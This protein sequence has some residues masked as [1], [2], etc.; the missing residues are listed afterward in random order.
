MNN[1]EFISSTMASEHLA[2]G[3]VVVQSARLRQGANLY[4]ILVEPGR[5][6]AVWQYW[7]NIRQETGLVPCLTSMRSSE[8]A[9]LSLAEGQVEGDAVQLRDGMR[10]DQADSLVADIVAKVAF[11]S[12]EKSCRDYPEELEEEQQLHDPVQLV[13]LLQEEIG[14]PLVGDP[15]AFQKRWGMSPLWLLLVESQAGFSLPALLPN[16]ANNART[17]F[18]ESRPLSVMDHC[19]FLRHWHARY[20]AEVFFVTSTEVQLQ[21]SFPPVRRDEIAALAI[22]QNAYCDDLYDVVELGDAQAR[23]TTWS[24]WWD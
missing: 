2:D 1:V 16:F 23:S 22:E 18:P 6:E 21:V 20:G 15:L 8:Q 17:A 10:V 3:P 13:E 7:H 4:G 14:T 24:F 12:I 9:L 11:Q 5:A 19:A